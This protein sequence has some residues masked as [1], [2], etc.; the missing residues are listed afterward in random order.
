[1]HYV[2]RFLEEPKWVL[3]ILELS[4]IGINK[5]QTG[6]LKAN[7]EFS[8]KCETGL[9]FKTVSSYKRNLGF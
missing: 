6:T 8:F 7:L 3:K 9:K 5:N 1:M 2:N 4:G